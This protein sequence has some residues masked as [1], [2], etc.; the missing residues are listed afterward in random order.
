MKVLTDATSKD[1]CV[2]SKTPD[3]KMALLVRRTLPERERMTRPLCQ[4]ENAFFLF[5]HASSPFP[6]MDHWEFFCKFNS[7]LLIFF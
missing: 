7:F 4:E 1:V 5:M 2:V 3:S 6:V